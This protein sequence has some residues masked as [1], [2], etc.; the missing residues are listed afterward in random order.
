MRRVL[1]TVS[2]L[3]IPIAGLYGLKLAHDRDGRFLAGCVLLICVGFVWI[4]RASEGRESTIP[5]KRLSNREVV[6]ET[7]LTPSWRRDL[8]IRRGVPSGWPYV[9]AIHDGLSTKA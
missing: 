7:L 2:G 3:G 5:M 1:V 6:Y 9:E 8:T 4:G